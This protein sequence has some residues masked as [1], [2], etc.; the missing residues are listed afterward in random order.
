[1]ASRLRGIIRAYL[2]SIAFWYGMSML[3]GLQYKPLDRHNLWFSFLDLLV[4][5]GMRAFALALWTPPIF[6]LAEKVA[7]YSANR[8]RYVLLWGLGAVPFVLIQ[9]AVLYLV[10]PPY[11]S[12]SIQTYLE[13]VRTSFADVTLIYVAIV[14]AAHAYAYL[15]RVRRQEA[16]RYEYQRA[17]A[18]SELQALKMQLQP[19]FLFN[20]LHG[21]ATLADED[22]K[23]AK[24]MII[25]LSNL[26]R[27]ALERDSSDLI[28]LESELKFAKEYLDLQ[29]MR[30]GNR[31]KVDWLVAPETSQLLVPQMILQPLVENAVQ[32][33]IASL[34]EGGWLEVATD[35]NNGTLNIRVR[36]SA[37]GKPSNGNGVGLRNVEAR[38]KYLYSGDASLHLA[39][40]DDRTV[41][42]SLALPA[43]NSLPGNT[44]GRRAHIVS[45]V[46]APEAPAS[47]T[48]VFNT[49]ASTTPASKTPASKTDDPLCA[50]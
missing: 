21:I 39:I 19:H 20:T 4:Q 11:V 34:R 15:K 49:P 13:I 6:Y 37:G 24:A 44:N 16:E 14:L 41:T 30:F 18:A 40:A 3:M 25:K 35:R 46:T 48:H 42:A 27:T 45:D 36:N 23:T 1:M 12:H 29:K 38:L 22:P 5:A 43:L 47:K 2:L 28:P 50:S 32:Y 26:L 31:L 17:L 7:S 8:V 33:G 9:L 10:V